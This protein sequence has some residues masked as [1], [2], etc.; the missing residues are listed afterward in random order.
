[1]AYVSLD[2]ATLAAGDV[3]TAEGRVADVLHIDRI[4]GYIVLRWRDQRVPTLLSWRAFLA[5]AH[6]YELYIP[7]PIDPN[8][9]YGVTP[10]GD[11]L[12]NPT[13]PPPD[14]V[15]VRFHPDGYEIVDW[16]DGS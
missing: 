16:P 14:T 5:V 13:R 4:E 3:V 2:P 6:A 15:W 1:M 8:Q 12:R 9:I 7:V 11:I 10:A